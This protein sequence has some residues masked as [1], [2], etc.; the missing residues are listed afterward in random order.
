MIRSF[1]GTFAFLSNFADSPIRWRGKNFATVEHAY[2]AAKAQDTKDF[3]EIRRAKTPGKAKKMGRK[4]KM[5]QDWEEVKVSIMEE[6]LR[7]KF[8]D[9]MLSVKLVQ[10]NGELVEGNTWHDNF[11]GDCECDK[12]SKPGT[13]MLGKLLMKIR[14]EHATRKR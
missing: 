12:C 8:S 10:L 9:P 13:N 7:L 6:L 4:V 5:R 14:S 2:Q 3:E 1:T 11:W